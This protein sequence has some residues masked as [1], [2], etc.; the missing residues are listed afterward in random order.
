MADSLDLPDFYSTMLATVSGAPSWSAKSE[1]VS[2][3]ASA[4]RLRARPLANTAPTHPA[5]FRLDLAQADPIVFI[6]S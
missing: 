3:P 6:V 2:E 5:D 4:A 1:Q